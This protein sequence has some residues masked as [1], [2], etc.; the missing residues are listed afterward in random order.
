MFYATIPDRCPYL[1]D[2]DMVSMFADPHQP[3]D[4]A[5]YGRL[6]RLGFRRSG[7]H[8]YRHQ[9]RNCKA[10]VPMRV[11][12]KNFAADRKQRRVQR[13]NQDL[14]VQVRD[15]VYDPR[16]FKLYQ[17]YVN[18]RHQGG[19]MDNPSS[20][21]YWAFIHSTWCK[22]LLVEFSL[23]DQL[24]CVAVI[25]ELPEALS[26]V[27]TFFEPEAE[28]RSLGTY[29]I[30]WQIAYAKQQQRPHLYLGYWNQETRKMA[31]KADF[32]PAHG[33]YDGIWKPLRDG[34][35]L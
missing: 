18:H 11:D 4:A 32:T 25:D 1:G 14:N 30:L 28:R 17:A 12:T 31:Y 20:E 27:Y 7:E 22:T 26:A 5:T 2:R 3:M 8:V 35:T 33:L 29:A 6:I 19:G 21:S 10:C 9:C 23:G 13:I 24:L 34:R 15:A 16:H